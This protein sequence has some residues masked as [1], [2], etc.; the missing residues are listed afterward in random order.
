MVDRDCYMLT[1]VTV[2]VLAFLMGLI[3]GVW[4]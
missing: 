1:M 4:L 2:S 3:L